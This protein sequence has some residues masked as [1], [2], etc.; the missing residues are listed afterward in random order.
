[1]IQQRN[2]W[3]FMNQLYGD[4]CIHDR[5]NVYVSNVTVVTM[6]CYGVVGSPLEMQMGMVRQGCSEYEV[7]GRLLH[8]LECARREAPLVARGWQWQ[9]EVRDE[10]QHPAGSAAS[11]CR[12]PG[13]ADGQLIHQRQLCGTQPCP[14]SNALVL[15]VELRST[16][17]MAF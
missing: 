13:R 11:R 15:I 1:M 7:A 9:G 6:H 16:P 17:V 8:Y 5:P 3:A 14:F 10:V 12:N 4:G 2:E